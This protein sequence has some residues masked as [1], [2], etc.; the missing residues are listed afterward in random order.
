LSVAHF[1]TDTGALTVPTLAIQANSPSAF[2]ISA[3]GKH[4]YST[5]YNSGNVSAFAIESKTGA[6][7]FL[8]S[9]PA[10]AGASYVS[11]DQTGR[12]LLGAN[13]KGGSV[14]VFALKPDGSLGE[15]TGFD[16]HTGH[17]PNASRQATPYA[18]CIIADP[19][20]RFLLSADLG[21][22]KVY[23]Y[24]FDASNGKIAPSDPPSV[25][26]TPGFGARHLAF[27]PNGKI[28][29]LIN[30]MGSALVAF[31][32]AADQGT[33]IQFQSISA[34]PADFKGEN[35]S[36]EI[37]VRADGR[38]LYV[39]NRGQD[40]IAA[41]SIDPIT[42]KLSPVQDISTQG[43]TP[44]VLCFDPTNKWIIAGNQDS[45]TAMVFK[46]DDKT[47]QLT[48]V[49]APVPV[50]APSCAGFLAGPEKSK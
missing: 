50:P 16:Q 48:P 41:F 19:T 7:K 2:V 44:R 40:S 24:K 32:W 14:D 39:T 13:G 3:D 49:G 43:K 4:L 37:L 1:D 28:L 45:N 9:A 27:H 30:E 8:N 5:N 12:Y 47:G 31:Q 35:V 20:N 6:L 46:V 18:H 34:L 23:L 38:F 26:V 17:G 10:G 33:L 15:R 42:F 22:D 21:T 36:A 29:Y 25:S 11:L